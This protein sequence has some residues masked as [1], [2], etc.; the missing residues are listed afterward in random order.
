MPKTNKDWFM[1]IFTLCFIVVFYT[2]AIFY[3]RGRASYDVLCIVLLVFICGIMSGLLII[4][5]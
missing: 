1:F 4:K 3:I 5:D 2:T